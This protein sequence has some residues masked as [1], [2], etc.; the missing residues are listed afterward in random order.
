M[1]VRQI[2]RSSDR[3]AQRPTAPVW[4]LVLFW[5]V[6]LPVL[7]L[8]LAGISAVA[9]R[10]LLPDELHVTT[11]IVGFPTHSGFNINR[12]FYNYYLVGLYLPIATVVA[13]VGLGSVF[14]W[15]VP[16]LARE[17]GRPAGREDEPVRPESRAPL[18]AGR[19][20]LVG[21]ALGLE[22][23]A[24]VSRTAEAAL[25]A[26]LGTLALYVIILKAVSL[27]PFGREL[28]ADRQLNEA[29]LNAFGLA[30][31]L[32]GLWLVSRATRVQVQSSG[33][34]HS[35]P[36]LALWLSLLATGLFLL[37]GWRG[38]RAAKGRPAW[39]AVERRAL[40]GLAGPICMFLVLSGLPGALP[41][42]DAYHY[43]EGL[44][45]QQLMRFGLFPWRDFLFIHG[46]LGDI[47]R[48]GIGTH[49]FQNSVWGGIA[50][51]VRFLVPLYW[52]GLYALA[53]RLFRDNVIGLFIAVALGLTMATP[54][55]QLRFLLVPIVLLAFV[56]LLE[57]GTWWRAASFTLVLAVQ[58][59]AGP[60]A[61]FA[62]PACGLAL[63]AFELTNAA[64]G[65]PWLARFARTYRCVVSGIAVT[66]LWF[67]YLALN[68]SAGAFVDGTL[69]FARG[70]RL[71]GGLPVDWGGLAFLVAVVVPVV[72]TQIA[73][74]L[75]AR[76][77]LRS[78][79]LSIENALLL[80]TTII[81][82]SYYT[83]F[84]SRADGHVFQ[85]LAA[86]YPLLL[87][88]GSRVLRDG[89]AAIARGQWWP[90]R[91]G[92]VSRP[93]TVFTLCVVIVSQREP[94]LNRVR[95][96]PAGYRVTVPAEPY[97]PRVGYSLPQA[98]DAA[99]VSDLGKALATYLSP[100]D[101]LFD[102][103][104]S[105]LLFHYLLPYVP[106]TKYFHVSLA[107]REDTQRDLIARLRASPPRIV[108]F[109]GAGFGLPVWDG[110]PNAVRHYEVSQYLLDNYKAFLRVRN[111]VLMAPTSVVTALPRPRDL[112]QAPSLNDL[113]YGVNPCDWGF[114]PN[115][116]APFRGT[117]ATPVAIRITSPLSVQI[118]L[119]AGRHWSDFR[120]LE[121]L[122][123]G[124]FRQ[125]DFAVSPPGAS[126]PATH[127]ITFRSLDTHRQT[128]QVRVGSCPAWH[129]Y[130]PGSL[131]VRFSRA[132]QI[133]G[134][135]LV[136]GPD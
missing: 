131:E 78:R 20:A 23:G 107:I 31:T 113:E 108:V 38:F 52:I 56:R 117:S 1:T 6:L 125:S 49:L 44:V 122:A 26:T 19:T 103:T 40:L 43:G 115:F 88:L 2:E 72:A 9:I 105:P 90:R 32:P 101:S 93:L 91:W 121:L 126:E 69:V 130:D 87:V 83:K 128:L 116:M 4:R 14:R 132:Q 84:L 74:W 92:A 100:G 61:A 133:S 110:I 15:F 8:A 36:W 45:P 82:A 89:D 129:A 65:S 28:A 46:F 106:S 25:V 71:T 10:K 127:T 96:V 114:S 64:P 120:A 21:L 11:D 5:R 99:A 29:R 118:T 111:F 119:P 54:Y 16:H 79:S 24:L 63:V 68:R 53:A 41:T 66:A 50:S 47:L 81:S 75:L 97:I 62:L 76:D 39:L 13:Y 135:R 35:Y 134:A 112:E 98:I 30:L 17:N 136:S 73:I 7:A 33:L 94:L 22:A 77:T 104:N 67:F 60:E 27:K 18:R 109:D 70:H 124:G 55:S 48:T 34:G 123:E 12:Y 37:W 86:A 58:V 57:V 95:Y 102:F 80:A 59:I 51:E 85:S 3:V 42:I